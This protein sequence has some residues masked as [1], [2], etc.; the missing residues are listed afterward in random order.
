MSKCLCVK[1]E[2][3]HSKTLCGD[4]KK[5]QEKKKK[6]NCLI[7]DQSRDVTFDPVKDVSSM[8]WKSERHDFAPGDKR[9]D[10][11]PAG[12]LSRAQQPDTMEH[13]SE[14]ESVD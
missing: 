9:C 11:T 4:L 5:F 6:K 3:T 12:W 1:H 8:N 14:E 13:A 2:C 7:D 10:C